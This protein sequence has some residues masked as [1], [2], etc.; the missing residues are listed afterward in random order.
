MVCVCM[1]APTDAVGN[2]LLK[3]GNF[4]QCLQGVY[5]VFPF[6]KLERIGTVSKLLDGQARIGSGMYDVEGEGALC[7]EEIRRLREKGVDAGTRI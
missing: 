4:V 6:W 1:S 5:K 3:P 2:L 7:C